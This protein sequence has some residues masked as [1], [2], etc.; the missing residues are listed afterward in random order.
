MT[1]LMIGKPDIF[2][3][4]FIEF[5][6][7]SQITRNLGEEIS[8]SVARDQKLGCLHFDRIWVVSIKKNK[9]RNKKK[10]LL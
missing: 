3:L 2:F 6:V 5:S 7:T 1:R 8:F 10:T 9:G 4:F